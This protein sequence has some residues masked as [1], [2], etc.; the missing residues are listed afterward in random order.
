MDCY[1]FYF[2]DFVRST[3]HLTLIERSVYREMLDLY[4]EKEDPLTPDLVRLA[5]SLGATSDEEQ[6]AVE[7]V[8]NDFFTRREDGYHNSRCDAEISR[9][10]V[11]VAA[12]RANGRRGGL[13]LGRAPKLAD[14]TA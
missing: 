12:A 10:L 1:K 7:T 8:L 9:H 6:K 13:R 11:R 2:R 4:Y 5:R 14:K 3:R